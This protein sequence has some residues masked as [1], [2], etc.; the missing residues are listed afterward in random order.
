MAGSFAGTLLK[1]L[2]VCIWSVIPYAF[3]TQSMLAMVL[4]LPVRKKAS[5]RLWEAERSVV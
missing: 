1:Y 2:G 5:L 3:L 4:D